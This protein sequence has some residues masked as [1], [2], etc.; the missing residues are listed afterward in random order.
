MRSFVAYLFFFSSFLGRVLCVSLKCLFT[1]R[2]ERIQS[3]LEKLLKILDLA[4][5]NTPRAGFGLENT[6]E[7]ESMNDHLEHVD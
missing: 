5:Y 3:Q 6:T 4:K 7:P 1:F 2:L